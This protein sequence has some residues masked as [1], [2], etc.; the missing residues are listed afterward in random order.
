MKLFCHRCW[1]EFEGIDHH[2]PAC[3]QVVAA[4]ES[5]KAIVN[6]T[7]AAARSAASSA[8]STRY[9]P[10]MSD[11]ARIAARDAERQRQEDAIVAEVRAEFAFKRLPKEE[12]DRILAEK[13]QAKA[14]AE[15]QAAKQQSKD[16]LSNTLNG[17]GTVIFCAILLWLLWI[18]LYPIRVVFGIFF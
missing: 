14:A 2:C 16:D 8:S 3:R 12:Q 6:A 4:E 1:T 7:N 18:V 11:D 13:A 15:S 9:Y 10:S 5:A 17:I